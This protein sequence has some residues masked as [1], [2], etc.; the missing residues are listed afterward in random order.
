MNVNVNRHLSHPLFA[1]WTKTLAKSI[2][3]SPG[4]LAGTHTCKAW[5]RE[6][7]RLSLAPGSRRASVRKR[8]HRHAYAVLDRYPVTKGHTLIIPRHHFPDLF[9]MARA[10]WEEVHDLLRVPRRQPLDEDPSIHSEFQRRRELR[11]GRQP[12][13]ALT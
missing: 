6:S 13:P 1:L 8:P 2:P 4:C 7:R 9:D 10:E 3:R 12:K 11:R 5:T